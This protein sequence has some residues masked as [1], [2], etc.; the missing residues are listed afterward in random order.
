MSLKCE[1]FAGFVQ[2]QNGLIV[3]CAFAECRSI[4]Q[5]MWEENFGT[6]AGVHSI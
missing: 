1:L 6:Q 4:L 2:R 5:T 3:V